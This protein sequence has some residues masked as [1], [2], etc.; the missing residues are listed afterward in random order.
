M[1]SFYRLRD[2]RDPGEDVER[3]HRLYVQLFN[4]LG[5]MYVRAWSDPGDWLGSLAV[6]FSVYAIPDTID[7][8]QLTPDEIKRTLSS[9]ED[10]TV[11]SVFDANV[12]SRILLATI[13]HSELA[14][15]FMPVDLPRKTVVRLLRFAENFHFERDESRFPVQASWLLASTTVDEEC[16]AVYFV[17]NESERYESVSKLLREAAVK[18]PSQF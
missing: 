9:I 5:P 6:D 7:S 11:Y 15:V 16:D 12:F 18:K 13:R 17:S 8:F 2:P 3:I 4:E 1:H 10:D 14:T